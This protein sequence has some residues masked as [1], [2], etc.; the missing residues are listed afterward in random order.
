MDDATT[1]SF[2][3]VKPTKHDFFLL[4]N[5]SSWLYYVKKCLVPSTQ[6]FATTNHKIIFSKSAKFLQNHFT[7]ELN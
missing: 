2:K 7:Y 1:Y 3:H 4:V 5:A 6:S